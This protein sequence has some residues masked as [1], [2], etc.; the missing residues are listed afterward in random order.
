MIV[1]GLGG[2]LNDPILRQPEVVDPT[3]NVQP[4]RPALPPGREAGIGGK[5]Q[6]AEQLCE[7]LI[8][9]RIS[10]SRVLLLLYRFTILHDSRVV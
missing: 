6:R 7:E 1:P 8:K 9:I 5:A 3:A 2:D 4:R 10:R